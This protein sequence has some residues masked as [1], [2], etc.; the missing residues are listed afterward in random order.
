MTLFALAIGPDWS[1][2]V[3]IATWPLVLVAA[4]VGTVIFCWRR[5]GT[6]GHVTIDG[7]SIGIGTQRIEVT[8]NRANR[9]IAHKLWVELSSRKLGMPIDFKNDVIVEIYNSWYAFFGITREIIKSVPPSR[10]SHPDTVRLVDTALDVLNLALRPH[11]TRWQARFRRWYVAE[12]DKPENAQAA[13]QD[14]QRQFEDYD[15][16]AAGL[17]EVNTRLIAYRDILKKMVV[18]L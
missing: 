4:V 16:M 17:A 15:E 9:E 7:G 8:I 11:L 13:P 3:T 6:G 14:I 18:K 10:L 12:I 1:V 2:V 5:W